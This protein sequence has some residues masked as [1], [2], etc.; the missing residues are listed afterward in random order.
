MRQVGGGNADARVPHGKTDL[1]VVAQTQRHLDLTTARCV[2]DRVADEVEKQLTQ[3]RG[4]AHDG[5]VFD[6][7]QGDRNTRVLSEND[8]GLEDIAH[9]RLELK[10]LAVQV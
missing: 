7:R 9:D 8:G 3:V 5:R 6:E 1:V 4:V 2:L 10:W